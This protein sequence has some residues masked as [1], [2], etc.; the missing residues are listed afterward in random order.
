[1]EAVGHTFID[2]TGLGKTLVKCAPA[3][4]P[5]HHGFFSFVLFVHASADVPDDI[6]G[7]LD[8]IG[9]DMYQSVRRVRRSKN[10]RSLK[11]NTDSSP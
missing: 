9:E 1:M 8:A 10:P 3:F 5:K 7:T 4:Q 11:G 2:I 6:M